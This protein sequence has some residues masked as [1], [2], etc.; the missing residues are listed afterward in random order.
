MVGVGRGHDH[1]HRLGC[2]G[3]GS[4][5]WGRKKV[6]ERSLVKERVSFGN[7]HDHDRG[8]M[9]RS[10]GVGRIAAAG[11]SGMKCCH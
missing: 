8:E 7:N 6:E 11:E 10:L 1:G 2:S 9:G 5:R 3:A 4:S